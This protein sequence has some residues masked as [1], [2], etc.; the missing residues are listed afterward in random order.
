MLT[1]I[2]SASCIFLSNMLTSGRQ[3]NGPKIIVFISMVFFVL[4]NSYYCGVLTM[5][6]TY[7]ASKLFE[8]E[9]DVMQARVVQDHCWKIF[10]SSCERSKSPVL[11]LIYRS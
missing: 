9:R 5:F 3:S 11:N 7:P 10:N 8:T 6:F 2:A 1:A 4:A